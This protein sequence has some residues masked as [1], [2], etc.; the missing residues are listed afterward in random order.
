MPSSLERS[1]NYAY[2]TKCFRNIIGLL[3]EIKCYVDVELLVQLLD[4]VIIFP[5][6]SYGCIVWGNSYDHNIKPLQRIKKKVIPLI[7]F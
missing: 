5:F 4:H 3:G 7:T 1:Y 2:P 6:L